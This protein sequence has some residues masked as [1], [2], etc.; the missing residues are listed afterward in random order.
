MQEFRKFLDEQKIPFTEADLAQNNDW[1]RSNIKAELFINEFG[2][3][4]GMR[5]HAENDPEVREGAGSAASGEAVGRQR[6]EGHRPAQQRSPDRAAERSA[7]QQPVT[8]CFPNLRQA[9][10]PLRRAFCYHWPLT[11]DRCSVIPSAAEGSV[12]GRRWQETTRPAGACTSSRACRPDRKVRPYFGPRSL[13][14]GRT[15]SRRPLSLRL[16]QLATALLT[17]TLLAGAPA[18]TWRSAPE[19]PSFPAAPVTPWL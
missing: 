17:F 19:A 12:V 9:Q 15:R 10:S 11:T 4:E 7:R 5:V 14:L 6:Q 3:Q 1:I 16:R 18:P 8:S 13:R 2:Q